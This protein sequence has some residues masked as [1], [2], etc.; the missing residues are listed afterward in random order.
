MSALNN[1]AGLYPPKGQQIWQSNFTWQPIPVHTIPIDGDY[2]LYPDT[3]CPRFTQLHNEYLQSFQI[4]Y[5]MQ[6]YRYFINFL[7]KHSGV[8]NIT[9]KD[10][11]LIYDTLLIQQSKGFA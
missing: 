9:L 5:I 4:K 1:L 7:Q 3:P 8:Q 11:A 2:L 10:V 6:K